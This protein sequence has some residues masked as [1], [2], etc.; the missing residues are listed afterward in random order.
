MADPI[1]LPRLQ[2]LRPGSRPLLT[3]AMVAALGLGLRLPGRR[4]RF[5]VE[6]WDHVP[7]SPC[8]LVSNHTHMMDWVALRWVAWRRGVALCNWVK[9][10]T[11]EEG[12]SGFLDQTGNLPVVSRGYLISADVR[13]TF[14]RPPSED[15]YR[16]LRDHLDRGTPLPDHPFYANVQSH[17]RDILGV[18]FDPSERSWRACLDD[19][20]HRMMQATL[21]HTRTL[22]DRGVHLQIMPQGVTSMRLTKGHPG[23]LQAALAL[24]LPLVPVGISGFPQAW[25]GKQEIPAHGGTVTVRV[26]APF[27]AEP[28]PG[29]TPFLP[30]SERDH[31]EAL[32]AGTAAM[33]AR[34]VPLLD[35]E[36]G[37]G[38]ESTLDVQGVARFV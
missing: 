30:A 13:A 25:G 6:G 4:V 32:A 19:L 24:D 12:W 3:G 38:D 16:H 34:I 26:G 10:R 2:A 1:T 15:E 27:R 22:L 36:H 7:S 35:P 29:H 23:A 21:T 28:I 9:P 8:L 20:F 17:R 18:P 31:A 37:P 14:G 33:M 5:V 11:Y